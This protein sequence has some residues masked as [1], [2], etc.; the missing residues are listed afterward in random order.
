MTD[1]F[2]KIMKD[3]KLQIQ[4]VQRTVGRINT[5]HTHTDTYSTFLKIKRSKENIEGGRQRKKKHTVFT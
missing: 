1:N 2:P 3:V 5:T 4:E